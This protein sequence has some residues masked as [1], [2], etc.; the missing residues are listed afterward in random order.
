MR[1]F[2]IL[3]C[4]SLLVGC[5]SMQSEESQLSSAKSKCANYGYQS[6]TT[7]MANCVRAEVNASK[8]AY[9]HRMRQLCKAAN[10]MTL[11]PDPNA[12]N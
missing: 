7:A 8:D 4:A 9:K 11:D 12:C 10:S 1:A 2:S 5:V 6:G 3:F